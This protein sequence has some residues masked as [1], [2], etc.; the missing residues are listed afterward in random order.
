MPSTI[1]S[2]LVI[3]DRA[4]A[5]VRGI[6]REVRGL[7]GDAEKAGRAL[8]A[9]AGPKAATEMQA[10]SDRTRTLKGDLRGLR[11]ELPLLNRQVDMYSRRLS[12]ATRETDRLVTST[13]RLAVSLR[14]VG[15]IDARPA[16][17]V[18]G[19][20]E[21]RAELAALRRDLRQ[22]GHETA[23]AR[24]R[25]VGSRSGASG[26]GGGARSGFYAG[27]GGVGAFTTRGPALAAAGLLLGRP[28]LGGAG[29]LGGSLLGAGLGA[30][31]VGTAGLGAL[32]V[33]GLGLASIMIPAKKEIEAAS[34]AQANYTRVVA[35]YG[36]ASKQAAAAQFTLNRAMAAAPAGTGS[37]LT[38]RDALRRDWRAATRPG[39]GSL[40]RLGAGAMARFRTRALPRVAGD[41]NQ[42]AAATEH[43]G[44]HLA[45]FLTGPQSLRTIDVL[46]H[47]FTGNLDE[48]EHSLENVLSTMSHLAVAATPFF[49]EG[50]VWLE[51]W[52]HGWAANTKD[53]AGTRHTMAGYINDLKAWAHLTSS[54]FGLA[55]DVLMGGRPSGTSM[56][57]DLTK[58]LTMWDRWVERNPRKMDEFFRNAVSDTDK[59]AHSL[60][61]AAVGLN[62]MAADLRPILS[63]L[64]RLVSLFGALSGSLSPGAAATILLGIR[65]GRSQI[66][67]R[68]GLNSML[69]GLGTV[70]GPGGSTGMLPLLLGGGAAAASAKVV[71]GL[72]L[73]E[74]GQRFSWARQLAAERS[75]WGG[76]G[77]TGTLEGVR[78]ASV[79]LTGATAR[80][81]LR[82]GGT[83]GRFALPALAI[84]GLQGAFSGA[85]ANQGHG[86]L[87]S[88]LW[89]VRNAAQGALAMF[90]I[91]HPVLGTDDRTNRGLSRATQFMSMLPGG[92]NPTTSQAASAARALRPELASAEQATANAFANR[93]NFA[94]AMAYLKALRAQAAAYRQIAKDAKHAGEVERNQ[95]S[96]DHAGRLT[97]S[98]G[99]ADDVLSKRF[100][101]EKAMDLTVHSVLDKMR[102]MNRTGAKI[103]GENVLSWARE[104]ARHNPALAGSVDW[105]TKH[106][107][108][109]F[110]KMGDHVLVVNGKILTG[111]AA[112]WKSIGDAISSPA[113]AARLKVGKAFDDIQQQAVG[114]LMA[115]GYSSSAATQFVRDAGA[116][117]VSAA[118]PAAALGP[119]D[120]GGATLD[121]SGRRAARAKKTGDGIGDG[122]G[123]RPRARAAAAGPANLMGANAGLGVYEKIG[124]NYGLGVSSGRR[125]GAITASGNVSLHATGDAIDEAGPAA[126]MLAYARFLA[127]NYGGGI[128]ELIHTPLGYGIKDGK[129]VPLSFWGPVI[130]AEHEGHVH[131]GD[132]TPPGGGA[133]G[134]SL[135]LSMDT[136][137]PGLHQVNLRAPRSGLGGVPGGLADAASTAYAAALGAKINALAGGGSGAGAL[138]GGGGGSAAGLRARFGLPA[139]FD[140]IRGAESG[141]NPNA[142]NASGA[143]GWYQIMMPL[144]AALVAQEAQRLGRPNDVYDPEVNT[145]VAADLYHESGLSPWAASRPKW[146]ASGDGLGWDRP[147]LAGGRPVAV[148]AGVSGRGA[149][150]TVNV[151]QGAVQVVV[152]GG[153]LSEQHVDAL[154]HQRIGEFVDAVLEDLHSGDQ[155]SVL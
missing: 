20:A 28:L 62:H 91:A 27:T 42:I 44:L 15:A 14:A 88:P 41:V 71:G 90:G 81:A 12:S 58:T 103:L 18:D 112:Q 64:E 72:T 49:H 66:A 55:K 129:R 54:A 8:D 80:G 10:V 119:V 134:L 145:A 31:A 138:G 131:V 104:Q 22:F 121:H 52:T 99:K 33:G 83:V 155:E 128:D 124:E 84:G 139:I 45:D 100:G 111:S 56:V 92:Q 29:A 47:S 154:V 117:K 132:R 107:E 59:I 152:G 149:G 95:R 116:G 140:A 24:A 127:S 108:A 74:R 34:K 1:E 126:G 19:I 101:P 16:V 70:Q 109:G 115:M 53:I 135:G 4:S 114:A 26:G 39:Q 89:A 93:N 32:G 85:G 130:N 11:D 153:G 110:S 7:Q 67:G 30:G 125:P 148:A 86:V 122:H 76:A 94:E 141:N 144:H 5:P 13:D 3:I 147:L 82:A 136:A 38:Q 23:T 48:A 113:E 60:A 87:S 151:H 6:R 150:H 75:L 43:Q 21:S 50:M 137:G 25:V 51:H 133:G 46:A 69:G 123:T 17:H 146:G 61:D 118:N 36:A 9:M 102:G 35:Q 40:M 77:L 98:F 68:G 65:A 105:L 97:T 96:R 78:A 79:G 2:A 143:S 142:H 63:P 120:Q 73:A 37:L 106:I 57:N